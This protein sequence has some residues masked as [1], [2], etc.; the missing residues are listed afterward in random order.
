MTTLQTLERALLCGSDIAPEMPHK[1]GKPGAHKNNAVIASLFLTEA[2]W[3]HPQFLKKAP[4]MHGL[5]IILH[6]ASHQIRELLGIAPGVVP[7][8]VVFVFVK[9]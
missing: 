6:V 1:V 5:V 8:S 7:R 9:S 3:E 2:I 4:R